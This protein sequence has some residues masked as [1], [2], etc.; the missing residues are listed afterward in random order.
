MEIPAE[1]VTI[2]SLMQFSVMVAVV[3]AITNVIRYITGY[4]ARWIGLFVALVIGALMWW[5]TSDQSMPALFL[6]AIN[7]VLVYVASTGGAAILAGMT[8]GPSIKSGREFTA[9]WW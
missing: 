1:F 8:A 3:W 2:E 5:F 9:R 7:A 4:D 6:A